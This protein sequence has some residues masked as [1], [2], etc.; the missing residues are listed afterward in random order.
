MVNRLLTLEQVLEF[1]QILNPFLIK[2]SAAII[3]EETYLNRFACAIFRNF[4]LIYGGT[5]SFIS[6]EKTIFRLNSTE[7]KLDF[8]VQFWN[9]TTGSFEKLPSMAISEIMPDVMKLEVDFPG[10]L[11]QVKRPFLDIEFLGDDHF[12]I[13]ENKSF[14]APTEPEKEIEA[15]VLILKNI[16]LNSKI[17]Y[18]TELCDKTNTISKFLD[19][20]VT[21]IL[22]KTHFQTREIVYAVGKICTEIVVR[23]E[24]ACRMESSEAVENWI[25]FVFFHVLEDEQAIMKLILKRIDSDLLPVFYQAVL[26]CN[27]ANPQKFVFDSVILVPSIEDCIEASHF[28]SSILKIQ[29]DRQYICPKILDFVHNCYKSQFLGVDDSL[30]FLI[31]LR[32]FD[33]A[34]ILEWDAFA[35]FIEGIT[36]WRLVI[37]KISDVLPEIDTA[38]FLDRVSAVN[39]GLIGCFAAQSDF[40]ARFMTRKELPFLM[41]FSEIVFQMNNFTFS[42]TDADQFEPYTGGLTFKT[43]DEGITFFLIQIFKLLHNG[44]TRSDLKQLLKLASRLHFD[45][46]TLTIFYSAMKWVLLRMQPRL[47]LR[48]YL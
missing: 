18:L 28:V 43:V 16:L 26:K 24:L 14:A 22:A 3:E 30:S 37:S 31:Y 27:L 41:W 47:L 34:A 7:E 32:Q 23:S 17:K 20:T 42:S 1:A 9:L 8:L 4:D 25:K 44:A 40:L 11:N 36:T 33:P 12:L 13:G 19:E 48:A 21:E 46:H 39:S 45:Y 29:T 10:I 38:D 6:D 15:Y 2:S 35:E 5:S